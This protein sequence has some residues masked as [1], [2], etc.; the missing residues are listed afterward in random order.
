[1]VCKWDIG[2]GSAII[3]TSKASTTINACNSKFFMYP[4]NDRKIVSSINN[5]CVNNYV[6]NYYVKKVSS[7]FIL[8]ERYKTDTKNPRTF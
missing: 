7:T 4:N 8:K 5:Y 1:M 2:C 3:D 6:N